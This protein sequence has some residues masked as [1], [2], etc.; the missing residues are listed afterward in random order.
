MP[1]VLKAEVL[2]EIPLPHLIDAL[3]DDGDGQEDAGAFDQL[4]AS[5]SN[6]VDAFL[7]GIYTTPFP[8]PAPAQVR[9]ATLTFVLEKVYLRRPVGEKNPY[10]ARANWWRER[11]EKIGQREIPLDAREVVVAPSQTGSQPV[12]PGRVPLA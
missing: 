10:A 8:D 2:G 1:Y 3:D 6:A 12:V 9:A 11:L 4:V 5:A 7:A